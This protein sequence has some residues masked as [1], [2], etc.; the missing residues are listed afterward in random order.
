MR[1]RIA[2]IFHR[3]KGVLGEWLLPLCFVLLG[4]TAFGLGRLSVMEGGGPRLLI[5]M[6]DGTTQSAAVY[7]ARETA[8]AAAV[9]APVSSGTYVASKSGTK[10]YPVGCSAAGRIKEGNRVYFATMAEAQAAGYSAATN[11]KN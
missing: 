10:F 5:Q 6:P 2:E 8:P 1:S 7:T 11:C 4:L 3:H 9:Q